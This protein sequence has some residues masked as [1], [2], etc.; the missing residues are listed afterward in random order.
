MPTQ[1][2]ISVIF[3]FVGYLFSVSL[4]SQDA[5]FAF[6]LNEAGAPITLSSE[7][8]EA[9]DYKYKHAQEI[10]DNLIM[11]KGDFTMSQPELI[12]NNG[13]RM[14]A[15]IDLNKAHLLLEEKAYDICQS[16]GKDSTN[17]LAILLAHELVHYYENHNWK[18]HFMHN[19]APDLDK[20]GDQLLDNH[21]K[22]EVEADQMGGFLAQTAG[23]SIQGILSPLLE[24]IYEAYTLDKDGGDK[25]PTLQERI[26]V[27]NRGE[28]KMTE[29]AEVF[30]M[31]NCLSVVGEFDLAIDYLN[32]ILIKEKFTSR[33]LHNNKGVLYGLAALQYFNA[34]E[35]KFIVPFQL[36]F[37]SRLSHRNIDKRKRDKYIRLA[38]DALKASSLLDENYLP[39]MVN[40]ATVYILSEDYFD[41]EY[42]CQKVL[43]KAKTK[44]EA[45]VN[46]LINLGIIA[47]F[48]DNN[49]LAKEY[50]Q[51]AYNQGG[52]TIAELNLNILEDK[53][54]PALSYPK[55]IEMQ[56][57]D[58]QVKQVFA[59]ISRGEL[60]AE[61]GINLNH[62]VAF[63]MNKNDEYDL[64]IN[65]VNFGDDAY[66]IFQRGH[67]LTINGN[68]LK[69]GDDLVKLLKELNLDPEV[70]GAQSVIHFSEYQ[71]I[72]ELNDDSRIE[73]FY[74]YSN[75][76]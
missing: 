17:A 13:E 60:E 64:L 35:F 51:K 44:S 61:F 1:N 50:F 63:Y 76:V 15:A 41:A 22:L 23:Y 62:E 28:Q 48:E 74:L 33:E 36:D 38:K 21:L 8:S 54:V 12:M 31:A 57:A 59:A 9:F 32:H 6:A 5:I 53:S 56:I 49:D 68:K 69:R 46:A 19:Y 10:L 71:L 40:L 2:K 70:V 47:A 72:V 14:P 25:Y 34:K 45:S 27:A 30:R 65:L 24:K 7:E 55:G 52:Q 37:K 16:F 67:H 39:A 3:L 20:S 18:E 43:K 29:M 4:I 26:N 75:K 73:A 58:L 42:L 11:A 66:Q